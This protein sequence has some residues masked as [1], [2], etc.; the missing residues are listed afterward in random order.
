LLD[1]MTT[2]SQAVLAFFIDRKERSELT[3]NKWTIQYA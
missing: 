1:M 3:L 2:F